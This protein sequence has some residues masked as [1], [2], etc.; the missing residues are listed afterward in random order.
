MTAKFTSQFP[1]ALNGVEFRTIRRKEV[2]LDSL[3]M[4]Y[5]PRSQNPGM[6]PAGIVQYEEN[7]TVVAAMSQYLLKK[8]MKCHGIKLLFEG[9]DQTPVI[10]TDPLQRLQILFGWGHGEAQGQCFPE[11]S[12]WCSVIHAAG[13]GT[14]LRTRGQS[15]FLLPDGGVFL[16]LRC[17]SGS[18]LAIKGRG[19]RRRNP[20]WRNKRWHC[21]TPRDMPNLSLR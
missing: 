3:A 18:D 14:H 12:T 15:H 19:L 1:Y 8:R 5:Q 9:C 13:S 10:D 2:K 4:L 6:M 11:E 20:N 7:L 21:R 17:A 16:Y